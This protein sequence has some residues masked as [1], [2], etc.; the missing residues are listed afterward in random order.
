MDAGKARAR[1]SRLLRRR[2]VA[3]SVADDVAFHLTDWADDL[4]AFHSFVSDPASLPAK[5]AHALLM[6]F[7]VHVPNHLA[8]ASKL[9][10]GLPVTDVFGVGATTEDER[11]T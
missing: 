5:Q 10:L 6:A 8:A 11:A 9:Y 1:I 4:E 7:L 2:G 3:S